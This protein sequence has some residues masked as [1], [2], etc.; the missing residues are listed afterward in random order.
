MRQNSWGA[1]STP[2]H[3]LNCWGLCRAAGRL[4]FI[5]EQT[6]PSTNITPPT[7]VPPH[8]PVILHPSTA[9]ENASLRPRMNSG[10]DLL[11]RQVW[12]SPGDEEEDLIGKF[13]CKSPGRSGLIQRQQTKS[14]CIYVT[15][16]KLYNAS[17]HYLTIL[18]FC[19]C[20][21]SQWSTPVKLYA[22]KLY[23]KVVE[24]ATRPTVS[25]EEAEMFIM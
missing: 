22:I 19:S 5:S 1:R 14:S 17:V 4:S 13:V 2:C 18:F 16:I 3:C 20:A 11:L 7:P 8:P 24:K 25:A 15:S 9:P 6:A 10:R 21:P 12:L 23:H